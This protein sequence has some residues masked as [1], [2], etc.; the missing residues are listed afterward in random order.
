MLYFQTRILFVSFIATVILSIFII[1]VLKKFKIGQIEREE[2][3]ESHYNKRGTPTMGGIIIALGIIIGI[4][5]G[6]IYYSTKEPEISKQ[7]LSLLIITIGFGIIGF[8]DDY[9]KLIQRDTKGLKPAYK[10]LGLLI[11]AVGYTLYLLRIVNLGTLTFIPFLRQYIELPNWFYLIFAIFVILGTTNAVNLT[12]GIDGLS[13]GVC[14]IITTCLTVIA[15]IL[16]VKEIVVF[17]SIIVGA[18]LGFLIFNLNTAKVFMGDTGSLLLG[19][20]IAAMALYL[21]MPIM[22]LVIAAV[23]VIETL[24]VVLQVVY[25]KIT[26]G[27]RLFKMAPIHHHFELSGWKEN[28][29]VSIFCIF[30]LMLCI[31]GLYGI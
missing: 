16:D 1:P 18:C 8:I 17:G 4:I 24:S 27:K 11:I 23:P 2:G 7:L 21:R 10:M 15:I 28:K 25:F 22:L 3:P 5:G 19:G 31:I 9:K 26:N 14:A 30:T 13:A 29:V 20:V 6:C 12:D